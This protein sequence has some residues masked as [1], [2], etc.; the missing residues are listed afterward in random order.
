MAVQSHDPRTQEVKQEDQKFKVTLSW[1]GKFKASLG[2]KDNISQRE[3]G[4]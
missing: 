3:E 4:G 2:Y 1:H